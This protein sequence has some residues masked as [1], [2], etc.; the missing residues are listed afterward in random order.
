MTTAAQLSENS[1]QGFDGIKAALCL[2]SMK[3]KSNT[4]SR[5]PLCLWQNSIGSRSSG[6]ERDAETGLDF[7]EARYFS[8]PQGRFTSPDPMLAK[9]EWLFDPQRWNRYAYVRNNPL[10]FI[11]PNGE[12]L[13]IYWSPGA[14]LS[15]R[16]REFWEK[17]KKQ[18]QGQIADKF[19]KLGVEKVNFV[20]GKSKEELAEIQKN[21][22]IGDVVLNINSSKYG[23]ESGQQ[24]VAGVGTYGGSDPSFHIG[25]VFIGRINNDLNSS[26]SN[27]LNGGAL[28]LATA[29]VASHE[30]GETVGLEKN[31]L[32]SAI[33]AIFNISRFRSNLMDDRQLV[34]REQKWFDKT[35]DR[36][37]RVVNEINKIGK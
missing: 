5:M 26:W 25:A 8:S 36:N 33:N 35:S 21:G 3:A 29:E 31:G 1:H 27:Q 22:T 28:G 12:D 10:K 4:A 2:E 23:D 32:V 7:F 14:D 19:H 15:E 13:N 16:E 9:K 17:Y 37:Q 30:I 20:E 18:I 34:P 24:Q 11:D 6:K